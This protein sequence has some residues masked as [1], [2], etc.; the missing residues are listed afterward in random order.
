MFKLSKY[1]CCS[2][3]TSMVFF[4]FAHNI[5]SVDSVDFYDN[6]PFSVFVK[7]LY[8]KCPLKIQYRAKDQGDKH[9]NINISML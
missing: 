1:H 3:S 2:K 7:M 5:F 9:I 6:M 4:I 8:Y